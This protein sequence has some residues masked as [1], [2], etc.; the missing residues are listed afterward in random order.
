[1][2]E[3]PSR[4]VISI[5]VVVTAAA[6]VAGVI[7]LAQIG[8]SNV[9]IQTTSD[10]ITAG[11][12]GELTRASDIVVL[13]TLE[14]EIGTR[15]V[16]QADPNHPGLSNE[17]F[18]IVRDFELSVERYLKGTGPDTIVMNLVIGVENELRGT[19][20]FE[21]AK[22]NP[23]VEGQRYVLFLKKVN[24]PGTGIDLAPTAE[25]WRFSITSGRAEVHS[26][27]S[28]PAGRFPTTEQALLE[29]IATSQ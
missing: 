27:V 12:V 20:F 15:K 18:G 9:V 24:E 25:P 26:P 2:V 7:L 4:L 6:L 14:R 11:S 10:Y 3:M 5:V 22:G 16:R 28:F 1:M 19:T 13:V 23:L 17:R 8:G 21:E 29:E